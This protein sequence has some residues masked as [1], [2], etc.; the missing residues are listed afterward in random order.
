MG[1]E[2][3]CTVTVGRR[4]LAGKALL[5]TTEL[6]FRSPELRLKVPFASITSAEAKGGRLVVA[7]DGER[8][9]FELGN[10]AERWAV[11]IR[12]PKSVIEKLGVKSGQRV[13]VL[14]ITDAAF[15]AALRERAAT[16]SNGRAMKECDAIFLGAEDLAGLK[17]IPTLLPYLTR[18]GAIWTVTPKGKGGVKDTDVM[19]AG[20]R[21]GL[22][23]V[24][25]VSFSATHSANKFVVP[26]AAR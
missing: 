10:L 1:A 17:R 16:V 13:A 11:K 12:N 15:L 25:V 5:E 7:W 8:A 6:L 26:K 9:T 14:G 22:A 2:A 24:K 3:A 23:D 20:K 18:G 21:A 19:A 4:R